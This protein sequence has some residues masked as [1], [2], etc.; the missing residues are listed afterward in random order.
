MSTKLTI[1][2]IIAF[3]DA[4]KH[5][6]ATSLTWEEAKPYLIQHVRETNV[7]F[8]LSCNF[9]D[10]ANVNKQGLALSVDEVIQLVK[11][12]YGTGW[13][14][15]VPMPLFV[16]PWISL[17]DGVRAL[18][19]WA[20]MTGASECPVGLARLEAYTKP[21]DELVVFYR[22]ISK[23]DVSFSN[24]FAFNVAVRRYAAAFTRIDCVD[25]MIDLL[26]VVGVRSVHCHPQVSAKSVREFCD[27]CNKK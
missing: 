7:P 10:L 26:S 15:D 6:T 19:L 2:Q 18:Q 22:F 17:E 11:C 20:R 9:S 12:L 16:A 24:I 25:N 5:C 13:V 27:L 21:V 8:P 1:A 14:L 23:F 4:L 3:G